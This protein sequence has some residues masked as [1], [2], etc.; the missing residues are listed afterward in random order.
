MR[1]RALAIT[2]HLHDHR[3]HG[4]PEWPPAPARLFQALI[5]GVGPGGLSED[6]RSALKWL[7][8]LAAPIVAAPAA[9]AGQSYSNYVPNND[10]DAIQHDPR[11]IS[12]IRSGKQI[13]PRML[14]TPSFV[15]LWYF[16][17]A[18]DDATNAESVRSLADHL[19][20][21]GRGV[22]MAWAYG[23]EISA[24]QADIIFERFPGRV[25][26]PSRGTGEELDC[27]TSGSL[28]SLEA[29]HRANIAR[30]RIE[31][32]TSGLREI[33]E[34]APR[35]EFDSVSYSARSFRRV[36]ELRHPT[37]E[38][39]APWPLI[40]ASALV[41]ALRDRAVERLKA[42]LPVAATDVERS[43][44]GRKADGTNGGLITARIRIAPLPSIGHEHA[45][46]AIRRVLVEVPAESPLL[47]ADVF[48]AFS[49]AD[50][51]DHHTGEIHAVLSPS[52]AT[53]M[54]DRFTESNR[55]WRTV[56]PVALPAVARRRR[57]DPARVTSE[58]KG[59]LERAAE[60]MQASVAVIQALRHADVL[61]NPQTIR[62][63]REP[64]D[65]HGS[66]AEAFATQSRFPKER[67]WHVSI[68]FQ[69]AIS[70]PLI[71]GDGRF[72]GLGVMAPASWQTGIFILQIEDGLCG[73]PDSTELTRALRRAL[74]ARVQRELGPDLALPS[75]VS[76][77]KPDRS[78]ARS[79]HLAF[80]FD[81][82]RRRLLVLA[83]HLIERRQAT[84]D[85]MQ[86]LHVVAVAIQ[87]FRT[88]RAGSAGLLTLRPID[89][90]TESDP[91]FA[92]SKTW[93]ATTP[94]TI[95]RH[96]KDVRA[97]HL[98]VSD[99][100]TECTRVGLPRPHV[101]PRDLRG[102]KG[103]GLTG[104]GS[105][106]FET[107]VQGPIILGR[108]RHFGGGLFVAAS[109]DGREWQRPIPST[110]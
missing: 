66:R 50:V 101:T 93:V 34:Q 70:G 95:V 108:T 55:I 42:A 56:T 94:Y 74:M 86:H 88:L 20:Q 44:V 61:V 90:V 67:L 81:A 25:Y 26:R 63:Q 35:P 6:H 77:H 97:D 68:E 110:P 79:A 30:F 7:E 59:G 4:V 14:A 71:I 46:L 39:F 104:R 73:H 105:L 82:Q 51:T 107:K 100:E 64:F 69:N 72:L 76:G 15:Y 1:D 52:G 65:R 109:A 106:T 31:R 3:Y 23:E 17:S 102:L 99:I 19:Y 96:A 53:R 9:A 80:V 91:L 21:F 8:A 10:L 62:V 83:P 89:V 40:R 78:P 98:F 45:D 57:I 58:A 18:P 60:E 22:D 47:A 29:R 92:N 48:W 13:A 33:L 36:F 16:S 11:R 38:A 49:G 43:L 37:T 28:E 75:F 27:P 87:D 85:E 41:V 5:A 103:T 32:S 54:L 2:V 24:E 12:E 84:R